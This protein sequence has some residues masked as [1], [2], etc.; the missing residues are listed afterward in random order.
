MENNLTL[1][2]VLLGCNRNAELLR[3]VGA[4]FDS[5]LGFLRRMRKKNVL[6]L[7]GLQNKSLTFFVL[8]VCRCWHL[9]C[10]ILIESFR[11]IVICSLNVLITICVFIEQ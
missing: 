11:K 10:Q 8:F 6:V 5:K 1:E 9:V 3:L 4:T 2:K 7:K